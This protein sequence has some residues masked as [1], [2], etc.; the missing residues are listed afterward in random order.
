MRTIADVGD[1][2]ESLP[3]HA[4]SDRYHSVD[5]WRGIACVMIVLAHSA[6]YTQG[7]NDPSTP[8]LIR[9]IFFLKNQMWVGVPI[10]FVI[11]GYCITASIAAK[12]F[13]H[14]DIKTYMLRRFKRIFPPYWAMLGIIAVMTLL[15]RIFGGNYLEQNGNNPI[16][17]P[18]WRDWSQIFGNITLTEE[19]RYHVFGA[20]RG[21]I[22]GVAWTL[23]YEEQFYLILGVLASLGRKYWWVCV[24]ILTLLT[25]PFF[26]LPS[27]RGFFFDGYWLLFSWGFYTYFA[28]KSK[29][30]LFYTYCMFFVLLCFAI[31]QLSLIGGFVS[32]VVQSSLLIGTIFGLLLIILNPYDSTIHSMKISRIFNWFGERCYSLYLV[33]FPIVSVISYQFSV[34]LGFCDPLSAICLVLPCCFIA[35]V[36]AAQFFHVAIERRFLGRKYT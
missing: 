33:H 15:E 30:P 25:I 26:G 14:F 6:N 7:L 11:S 34:K 3:V 1:G 27:V 2:L 28:I 9:C 10:F 19:W 35:S 36:V 18:W 31:F 12:D 17:P 24:L 32:N 21:M 8:M 20:N 5:T 29:Y 23:C 4:S 13:D 22:L 16:I